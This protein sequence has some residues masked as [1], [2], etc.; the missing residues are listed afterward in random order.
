MFYPLSLFPSLVFP[1]SPPKPTHLLSSSLTAPVISMHSFSSCLSCLPV[2]F[3]RDTRTPRMYQEASSSVLK[4]SGRT[5]VIIIV[6][7]FSETHSIPSCPPPHPPPGAK[8]RSEHASDIALAPL[9]GT[10]RFKGCTV[11]CSPPTSP[12]GEQT[13]IASWA[14][15]IA[16]QRTNAIKRASLQR[17]SVKQTNFLPPSSRSPLS[18]RL[19]PYPSVVPHK[20]DSPS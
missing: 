20:L 12:D 16:R 7:C 15:Q 6:K 18:P 1:S 19:P 9:P 3:S 14:S 8:G 10:L 5:A 2:S 11:P 4:P 17:R 13:N